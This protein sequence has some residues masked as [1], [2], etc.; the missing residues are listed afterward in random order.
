MHEAHLQISK[1]AIIA[2]SGLYLRCELPRR[3]E[4]E[5]SK[6]AMLRKQCQDRK[7]KCGS[8]PGAGLRRADQIFSGQDNWKCAELNRRRFDKT[9]RVRT[10]HDVR[11]KSE[12]VK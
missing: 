5:T 8:F 2:K 1:A 6:S 4:H 3:L 7:S 10:A 9:H 11:R 12:M